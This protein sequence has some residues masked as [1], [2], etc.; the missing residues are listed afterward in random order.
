MGRGDRAI[1]RGQ[2]YRTTAVLAESITFVAMRYSNAPISIDC[3]N[4]EFTCLRSRR[5]LGN[6][7]ESCLVQMLDDRIKHFLGITL[8][9]KAR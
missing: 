2:D 4:R 6:I 3:A 1:W 5:P 7:N 8:I 9:A